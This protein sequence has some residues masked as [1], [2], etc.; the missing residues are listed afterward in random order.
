MRGYKYKLEVLSIS[1]SWTTAA[2]REKEGYVTTPSTTPLPCA[3]VLSL[4]VRAETFATRGVSSLKKD[5]AIWLPGEFLH[6][7]LF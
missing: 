5:S 6:I 7:S 1:G 2:D 3:D 4:V